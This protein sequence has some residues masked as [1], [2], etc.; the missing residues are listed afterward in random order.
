MGLVRLVMMEMAIVLEDVNV[1]RRNE[2]LGTRVES[3]FN[4]SRECIL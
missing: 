3:S 4:E 1:V 2:V